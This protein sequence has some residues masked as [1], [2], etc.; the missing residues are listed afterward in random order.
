MRSVS[1]R[2]HDYI[3]NVAHTVTLDHSGLLPAACALIAC[4]YI[5]LIELTFPLLS[6]NTV[7][8]VCSSASG[9]IGPRSGNLLTMY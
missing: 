1:R 8:T 7:L 9:A 4:T 6:S 3:A 2:T 5:E